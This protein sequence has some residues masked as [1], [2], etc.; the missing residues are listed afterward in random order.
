MEQNPGK[1]QNRVPFLPLIP[2]FSLCCLFGEVSGF[3]A[4]KLPYRKGCLKPV[5]EDR[6]VAGKIHLPAAN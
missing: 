5:L 2:S 6:S 1:S 3:S 4:R